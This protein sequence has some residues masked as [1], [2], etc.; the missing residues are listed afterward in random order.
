MN[1]LLNKISEAW[2]KTMHSAPM[3]PSRGSYQC[4]VCLRRFPVTWEA[5]PESDATA[6]AT[7][8]LSRAF[9]GEGR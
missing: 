4:R 8:A 1:N 2:C 9:A 5:K 7:A 3:W 6:A